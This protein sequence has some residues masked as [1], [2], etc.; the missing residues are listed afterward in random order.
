MSLDRANIDASIDTNVTTN[1]NKEITGAI[2]NAELKKI[3]A[4]FANLIDEAHLLGIREYD[5]SKTYADGQGVFYA[6]GIYQAK[7]DAITGAF[8]SLKWDLIVQVTSPTDYDFVPYDNATTYLNTDRVLYQNRFFICDSDGTIGIIPIDSAP[9]WT[10]VSASSGIFGADWETG[11][12]LNGVIIT[13]DNKMYYLDVATPPSYNSTDIVAE[14]GS[15]DWKLFNN[16]AELTP[17]VVKSLYEGNSDTNAFTDS[18]KTLLS[19]QSNTNSGDEPDATLLVKGIIQLATQAEVD[20]GVDELKAVTPETLQN[21]PP[22]PDATKVPLSGTIATITG[23]LDNSQKASL[24]TSHNELS[25]IDTKTIKEDILLNNQLTINNRQ[26]LVDAGTLVSGVITL[27]T[28]VYALGG[29]IDLAGDRIDFETDA[30]VGFTS[31]SVKNNIL[32]ST[33]L[34]GNL[35]TILDAEVAFRGITIKCETGNFIFATNTAKTKELIIDGCIINDFIQLGIINGFKDIH[36]E[37]THFAS[38]NSGFTITGSIVH[39]H[40]NQNFI[41]HS[42]FSGTGASTFIYFNNFVNN[43]L[44]ITNTN[45]ESAQAG[46]IAIDVSSGATFDT[47][48]VIQRNQ[49]LNY[50]VLVLNGADANTLNWHISSRTNVGLAGLFLSAETICLGSYSTTSTAFGEVP[51]TLPINTATNIEPNATK[52]KGTLI[53]SISH[54]Q[55]GEDVEVDLYNKTDAVVVSGSAFTATITTANVYEVLES[56]EFTMLESKEYRVRFRRATGA[57]S[58]TAQ[59]R[60]G[61]VQLKVY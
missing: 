1:G 17:A 48:A 15:G 37:E 61:K 54:S 38:F 12:Y 28:G 11:Y 7:F 42:R 33:G 29:T 2:L 50:T 26:D 16:H 44:D 24:M 49:F 36:I 8:D 58:N 10:E 51:E 52:V 4:N 22:N 30:I 13:Y 14:I 46:D 40:L 23:K 57:G 34:V 43:V 20:A 9:E 3:T 45:F 59:M 18:E 32:T 47:S 6:R 21:T 35:I 19:N 60:S 27:P 56:L 41:N 25:L 5:S 31:G 53:V 39:L 55:A